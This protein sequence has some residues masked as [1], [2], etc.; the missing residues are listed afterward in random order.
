MDIT[1][2]NQVLNL[3]IYLRIRL[4]TGD[5]DCLDSDWEEADDKTDTSRNTIGV[6]TKRKLPIHEMTFKKKTKI[7]RV[8]PP[9]IPERLSLQYKTENSVYLPPTPISAFPRLLADGQAFPLDTSKGHN[10]RSS[11]SPDLAS[12]STDQKDKPSTTHVCQILARE[13]YDHP[14]EALISISKRLE[15]RYQG[16]KW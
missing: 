9:Q 15:T 5:L 12:C 1:R 16:R 10:G 11:L 2:F 4:K 13:I 8:T 3:G 14:D 6:V 7:D